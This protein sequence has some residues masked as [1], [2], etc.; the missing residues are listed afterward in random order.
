MNQKFPVA[1]SWRAGVRW[2]QRGFSAFLASP[3]KL[4]FIANLQEYIKFKIA[5]TISNQVLI[6]MLTLSG[7]LSPFILAVLTFIAIGLVTTPLLTCWMLWCI[8]NFQN[9]QV[10][11]FTH[12]YRSM[13]GSVWKKI[14]SSYAVFYFIQL[15]CVVSGVVVLEKCLNFRG[16][17]VHASNACAKWYENTKN[18]QE[19]IAILQNN[20]YNMQLIGGVSCVVGLVLMLTSLMSIYIFASFVF[21]NTSL[22]LWHRLR[23]MLRMLSS[24]WPALLVFTLLIVFLGSFSLMCSALFYTFGTLGIFIASLLRTGILSAVMCGGVY[25]AWC[26]ISD[27]GGQSSDTPQDLGKFFA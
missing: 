17:L 21:E 11:G 14:Y 13:I 24:Y 25:C 8:G 3:I 4:L 20:P 10:T 12:F 5:L 9:T 1:L 15:A 7:G 16:N 18:V 23:S 22:S 27:K 19:C 2:F 6:L 26:E